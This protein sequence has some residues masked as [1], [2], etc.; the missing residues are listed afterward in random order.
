MTASNLPFPADFLWGAATA[1]YQIEGAV[2]EDG[3][4]PSIWDTFSHTPGAV[5]RGENGDVACDHYHRWPE[6]VALMRE[7][8]LRGYRFSV[9]WSRVQPEGTGAV[10]RPGLDFYARLVDALLE[11]GITPALTL[12][13]WDLPQAL[14][15]GGGWC[16]RDTAARFA[17]YAAVVFGEFG[18]R[19]PLW[20]T[21]NEPFCSSFVGYGEGRHAPGVRSGE[22]ALAAAHHLLLAHGL[23]VEAMRGA[24]G[25]GHPARFGIT[26]NVHD[27]LP[28]GDGEADRAAVRRSDCQ[29]NRVFLDPLLAGR[30]P[31]AEQETWP[32]LTDW[33]FRRDGDL[34]VIGT[35]LDF[36]G[37][38]TYF[39]A[40]VADRPR[41]EPDP[42]RRIATDIGVVEV[43]PAGLS[44]TAM[45]WPVEPEIMY[46]LLGWL[47]ADYPELPPVY[48]TENGI[49]C[50]DVVGPDGIVHDGDRISYLDGHLRALRRAMAEGADVRG[51]FAWSLMDNFEWARGFGMRFGL[52]QVDYGTLARTP[53]DSFAWYREVIRAGGL[54]G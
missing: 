12:Y 31:R 44:R 42:A 43:P 8:G 9:S 50:H 17:D 7:L 29:N 11:A 24:A 47:R 48:I 13:H 30:Y 53:K 45:G 51:Y 18:D 40:Y 4:G 54:P 33:G 36:L 16:S 26:L 27:T 34:D 14:E 20:I 28:A 22:G 46:R 3:R 39:P 32:G 21:L 1:A 19:V 10:N 2:T 52:V 49:A 41:V 23:A 6:D 38:N 5:E 37:V 35:P 25:S 15:D